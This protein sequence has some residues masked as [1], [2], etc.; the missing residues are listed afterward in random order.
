MDMYFYDDQD[1]TETEE[2]LSA[3]SSLLQ[4]ADYSYDI[5]VYDIWMIAE[6]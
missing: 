4:H 1:H 2:W 3:F 5:Y 6:K